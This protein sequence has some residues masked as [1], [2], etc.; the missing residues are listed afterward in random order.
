M[1]PSCAAKRTVECGAAALVALLACAAAFAQPA[2]RAA[3]DDRAQL[4]SQIRARAQ[5]RAQRLIGEAAAASAPAAAAQVPAASAGVEPPPSRITAAPRSTPC[6]TARLQTALAD[7][8][9]ELAERGDDAALHERVGDLLRSLGQ[10]RDAL[11]AYQRSAALGNAD[12]ARLPQ[13]IGALNAV[14]GSA[15]APLVP[16]ATPPIASP[17]PGKFHALVIGNNR[18]RDFTPLLTA[19]A[20][21]RLVGDLLRGQYGFEVETLENASRQD[22]IQA[23]SRLRRVTTDADRVLIYYAGHGI[24]DEKT[25]RG[26]WLPVDAQADSVANWVSSNDISDLA[27]AM[28]ARHALIVADSCFSGAL[29]RAGLGITLDERAGVLQRLAAK[30]S[31]TVLTSG[32]LEPVLDAGAGQHSVFARAFVDALSEN[33]E[34]LE[35][36]RLFIEL[37][38]RV[39]RA[40]EQTPQY[41]QLHDAGH[42]GG[43]FVFVPSVTRKTLNAAPR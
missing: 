16:E 11:T 18:Y 40:A 41:A 42:D 34:P 39:V 3:E 26:Y 10:G 38:S 27:A 17:P 37:R 7:C 32:G 29:T 4:Q 31:R 24:R 30:R 15:P 35:A 36:A 1:V 9:R 21:A 22:I 25:G 8:R 33:K 12:K 2:P 43:D 23:M 28:P 19:V 6:W 20:D 13:K 14:L 5:A